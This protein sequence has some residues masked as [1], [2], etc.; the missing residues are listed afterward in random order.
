[1]HSPRTL[2]LTHT[3][4]PHYFFHLDYLFIYKYALP[5]QKS[6]LSDH[7]NPL[8]FESIS[9]FQSSASQPCPTRS[10]TSSLRPTPEPPRPILSRPAPS[11]RT[12]TLSSKTGPARFDLYLFSLIYGHFLQIFAPFC[13]ILWFRFARGSLLYRFC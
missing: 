12:V 8:L 6:R 4:S 9:S 11:E 7:P 2:S 1:M 3:R 5:S 13:S 10:T